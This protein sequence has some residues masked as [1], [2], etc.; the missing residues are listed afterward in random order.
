MSVEFLEEEESRKQLLSCLGLFQDGMD[1]DSMGK[2]ILEY[3][4]ANCGAAQP[5]PSP[6]CTSTG[7]VGRVLT[8]SGSPIPNTKV[9]VK[10]TNISV[11]TN[12][13][14]EFQIQFPSPG[15]TLIFQAVRFISTERNICDEKTITVTLIQENQSTSPETGVVAVAVN[16]LST[17]DLMKVAS[18]RGLV[19]ANSTS[20]T[21]TLIRLIEDDKQEV[22]LK[23]EEL[24][25]LKN[26][27]LKVIADSKDLRYRNNSTKASLV[28]L[29]TGK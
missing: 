20:D 7:V 28:N 17:D 29:I 16:V 6:S 23:T 8:P 19:S 18:A 21:N 9:S 25:L 2:A 13:K 14:G 27:T 22:T 11:L 3:Q 10:G 1:Y 4:A 12:E 5:S 26:D 24:S 15:Q